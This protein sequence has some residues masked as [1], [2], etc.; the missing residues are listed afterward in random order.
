MAM[1]QVMRTPP[2]AGEGKAMG[3]LL[4]SLGKQGSGATLTLAQ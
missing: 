1:N 3:S 2:G 4:E